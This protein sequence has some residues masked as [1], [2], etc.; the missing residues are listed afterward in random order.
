MNSSA[1]APSR[2]TW[3]GLVTWLSRSARSVSST[4]WRL[5]STR[6]IS[7]RISCMAGPFPEGEVEGRA[8]IDFRLGPHAAAVAV[9]D[10]LDNGQADA[11]PFVLLG[12]V[13]ALEDRKELVRVAHV[14]ADAVV[15]DEPGGLAPLRPAADLDLRRL[16]PPRELQGV[17]EQVDQD[18]PEERRVPLPHG[19]V[20]DGNL[21]APPR[22]FGAQLGE[23]LACEAGHLDPLDFQRLAAQAG[24]TEQVVD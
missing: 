6:R 7:T 18:L 4:S 10:P 20:A 9:D 15:P 13:Q 22:L 5:S 14:E 21:N 24:E 16:A 1:S 2:T 17:G 19:H 8:L 23:R 11:R 3:T 12:P